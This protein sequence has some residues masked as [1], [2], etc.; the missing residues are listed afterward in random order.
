MVIDQLDIHIFIFKNSF[1]HFF[2]RFIFGFHRYNAVYIHI[3]QVI[4][5][6]IIGLRLYR[7]K[8]FTYPHFIHIQRNIRYL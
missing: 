7:I 4:P 8:Y 3:F 1:Q 2:N 5:E 6:R